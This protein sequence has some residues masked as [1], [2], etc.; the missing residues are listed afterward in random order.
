MLAIVLNTQSH[1][2][3]ETNCYLDG[4]IVHPEDKGGAVSQAPDSFLFT[5]KSLYILFSEPIFW[6]LTKLMEELDPLLLVAPC[7]VYHPSAWVPSSVSEEIESLL[8]PLQLG[9]GTRMGAEA[10]VHAARSFLMDMAS[11]HLLL[12]VDF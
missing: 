5:T 7:V 12:K 3:A 10:A 11:N 1:A 6:V 4:L 9:F 8:F 2:Q